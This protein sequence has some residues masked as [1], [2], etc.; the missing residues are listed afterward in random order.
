MR[1][2]IIFISFAPGSSLWR[3][4]NVTGRAREQ[5]STSIKFCNW[6]LILLSFA[7]HPAAAPR[8]DNAD[9]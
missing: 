4:T 7:L 3:G 9:A 1:R 5:S 8:P 6:F 2:K